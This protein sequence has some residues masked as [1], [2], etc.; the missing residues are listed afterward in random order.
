MLCYWLIPTP[1]VYIH[2]TGMAH[3]RILEIFCIF[4]FLFF[5]GLL[6]DSS[7]DST[8]IASTVMLGGPHTVLWVVLAILFILMHFIALSFLLPHALICLP[9]WW[10]WQ[11]PL[12]YE[13]TSKTLHG[14]T[15][16]LWLLWEPHL[17]SHLHLRCIIPVVSYVNQE[18]VGTSKHNCLCILFI[19]LTTCFG[20]CGP[21]SGHKNM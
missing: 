3:F 11:N 8:N 21:S 6:P 20:H 13:H 15:S 9:W 14:I 4:P 5:S 19:R 16:S 17:I 1:I 2:T 18:G 7:M 12:K 10:R